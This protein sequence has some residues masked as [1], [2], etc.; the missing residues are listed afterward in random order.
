MNNYPSSSNFGTVVFLVLI[1][2]GTG[3]LMYHSYEITVQN[4]QLEQQVASLQSTNASLNGENTALKTENE[5]LRA[6]IGGLQNE[7]NSLKT[8][9]AGLENNLSTLGTEMARLQAENTALQTENTALKS[10]NTS[11]SQATNPVIPVTGNPETIVQSGFLPSSLESSMTV[12][13]LLFLA[14]LFAC[15]AAFALLR[16]VW[17]KRAVLRSRGGNRRVINSHFVNR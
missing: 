10:E 3:L 1:F 13:A 9:K 8:E 12:A 7:N 16:D 4:G 2:I 15:Y 6:N 11:L 5:T 14:L 17:H